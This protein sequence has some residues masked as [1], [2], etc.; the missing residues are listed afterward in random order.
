LRR[1]SE[2]T[3]EHARFKILFWIRRNDHFGSEMLFYIWL[4]TDIKWCIFRSWHIGIDS[5]SMTE[6]EGTRGRLEGRCSGRIRCA[7]SWVKTLSS[8]I[9][10]LWAVV[11]DQEWKYTPGGVLIIIIIIICRCVYFGSEITIQLC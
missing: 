6:M 3:F 7:S 8:A 4:G 2:V 11:H 10:N 9:T 5:Y 1:K